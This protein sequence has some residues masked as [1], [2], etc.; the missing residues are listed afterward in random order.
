MSY[1][2]EKSFEKPLNADVPAALITAVIEIKTNKGWSIKRMVTAAL[3]D[4]V[5]ANEDAQRQS[6]ENAYENYSEDG[7]LITPADDDRLVDD[8]L[9]GSRGGKRR[10]KGA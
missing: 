1:M 6:Y 7:M 5:C 9:R 4:F 2:A 10:A 3:T 8:A